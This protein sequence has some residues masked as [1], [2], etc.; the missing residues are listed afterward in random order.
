[1]VLCERMQK[2]T[3]AKLQHDI[4]RCRTETSL[5]DLT[6]FTIRLKH[7]SALT[8]HV[9]FSL[10]RLYHQKPKIDSVSSDAIN[11]VSGGFLRIKNK[12]LGQSLNY[13]AVLPG[14]SLLHIQT[15][16]IMVASLSLDFC[17]DISE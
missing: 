10:H 15:F 5:Q 16:I 9:F 7:S 12:I 14:H 4:F 13:E 6:D 1:M 2:K 8:L 3:P 17:Q 11:T